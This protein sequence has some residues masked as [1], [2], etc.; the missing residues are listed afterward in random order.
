MRAA[1]PPVLD[2]RDD[3]QIL[4]QLRKLAARL[5]PEWKGDP[6]AKPDAG[7]M[8]HRIFTRLMEI[9]LERLNKA[10]G[11]NLYAFLNAV[12]VSLLPPVPARVPL[13]FSLT[14]GSAPVLVP[15]GTRAS[16]TPKGGQQPVD[17]ETTADLTVVPAALVAAWT[18]D[19][20]W[21]RS[22]GHSALIDGS[23]G[24]GFTPLLGASRLSHALFLGDERLLDFNRAEVTVTSD[25]PNSQEVKNQF[26]GIVWQ[27]VSNGHAINLAGN[28]SATANQI[29]FEAVNALDQTILKG[30]S[31]S[32]SLRRGLRSHWLH[33]AL[34]RPLAEDDG[35]ES[36][37]LKNLR[38][39][40]SGKGILPDFAFA[41]AVPLDVTMPFHPF[42]ETPKIGDAFCLT[43]SEALAKPNA[44]LTLSFV[45]KATPQEASLQWEFFGTAGWTK[46][47]S[48]Q[49]ETASL[50]NSGNVVLK[51]ADLILGKINGKDGLWIRVRIASGDY[52][53][54]AEYVEIDP[55][56]PSRGFKLKDDTGN[57]APPLVATL[58][59]SYRADGIPQSVVTQNGFLLTDQTVANGS[60]FNPFVGVQKLTPRIYA[61]TAPS[62]YLGFDKVFPEEPMTLFFVV[63]PRAFSGRPTKEQA[64]AAP[65][66][67]DQPSVRWEYFNGAAWV[68]LSVLD[69]TSQFTQSG[70]VDILTP[71]N[72]APL[73]KFDLKEIYWIRAM[74]IPSRDGPATNANKPLR[75]DPIT[76]PRLTAIFLNT[77][78]AIQALTV[79]NEIAGSGNSLPGQTLRLA[80]S[81][82]LAG[83]QILVLEPELPSAVERDELLKEEGSD[84]I[85][86]RINP[87]T[88]ETEIWIRWHEISSF[89][90]SAP[91]SRHY[92]LD[93]GTGDVVFGDGVRGLVPSLGT[94]NIVA[95]YR[96]GAGSAGNVPKGAVA[97]AQVPR[98]RCSFCRQSAEC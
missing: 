89:N 49:D 10:P 52:G 95:N 58:T 73:A 69:Q 87:A 48:A 47:D 33:A 35:A 53:K 29:T 46:F 12:G 92:T 94:N 55:N 37:T 51:L 76:T 71:A 25:G 68:E 20:G 66:P 61:D 57:L 63:A 27:Y 28:I 56:D 19:P 2:R 77:V 22:A 45:C 9:T 81:P 4:G 65:A 26:R 16:T 7:T 30:P 1:P 84:A 64:A 70:T 75:D 42:G 72:M 8:L 5:V 85:E 39:S 14:S 43:C 88:D 67:S 82:I 13:T 24:I 96:V 23:S 80:Q 79:A 32:A 40:V 60:G 74:Q 11:M 91:Y 21:D 50:S 54:P 6:N 15:Q 97:Q 83:P 41:N 86:R 44:R 17:F 98:G 78:P 34:P 18:M 62:L 90:G 38:L 36:L 93:H 31:D 3:E 59:L